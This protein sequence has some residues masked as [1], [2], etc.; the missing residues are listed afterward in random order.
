[1]RDIQEGAKIRGIALIEEPVVGKWKAIVGTTKGIIDVIRRFREKFEVYDEAKGGYAKLV[2]DDATTKGAKRTKLRDIA[3]AVAAYLGAH[4]GEARMAQVTK[5]VGLRQ[6]DYNARIKEQVKKDWDLGRAH[7]FYALFDDL[8]EIVERPGGGMV[9]LR[10]AE[11][12]GPGAAG[13]AEAPVRPRL[14]V[15]APPR[16]PGPPR[17]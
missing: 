7:P 4:G 5:D 17:P 12:A 2:G 15:K 13:P 11:A 9:R 3:D 8:F 16:P 10:A 1:M 14:R 6:G